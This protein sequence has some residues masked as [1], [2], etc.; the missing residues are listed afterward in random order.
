MAILDSA[1]RAQEPDCLALRAAIMAV[2]TDKTELGGPLAIVEF[3]GRKLPVVVR[4]TFGAESQGLADGLSTASFIAG[5]IDELQYGCKSAAVL[6][7]QISTGTLQTKVDAVI[8]AQSVFRA[9]TADEVKPPSEKHLFY[10]IKMIRDML[11]QGSLRRLYWADTRDM[12]CDCLT[13]G[14][15]DREKLLAAWRTGV[16]EIQGDPPEMWSAGPG[17]AYRK[18]ADDQKS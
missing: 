7:E 17:S 1:F 6:Q 12:L 13:K 18:S 4:S 2:T 11:E 15:V 16:W 3:Y 14:G 8:D 10:I 9:I 5:F